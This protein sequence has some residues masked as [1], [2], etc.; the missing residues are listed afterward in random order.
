MLPSKFAKQGEMAQRAR[1]RVAGLELQERPEATGQLARN[2][3]MARVLY[4]CHRP[5]DLAAYGHPICHLHFGSRKQL[6]P[7]SCQR[8]G[9]LYEC[10][11]RSNGGKHT[12]ITGDKPEIS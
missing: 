8:S 12:H 3:G 6:L 9:I 10:I 2:Y 1:A 11:V 4:G 7:D 5:E